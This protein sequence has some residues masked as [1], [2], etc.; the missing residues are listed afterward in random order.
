MNNHRIKFT[1]KE[2]GCDR[3]HYLTQEDVEV[4]LSR[5]PTELYARL[6]VVHFNDWQQRGRRTYGYVTTRGRRE[7]AICAL[8]P[9]VSLSRALGRRQSPAEYGARRQKQ[10]PRLPVRRF[11]LYEVFLHE[12]GHLQIINPKAKDPRRKFA[13]EKY[14]E[15]FATTWR[16]KLWS[17]PFDHP[18]RVHNPPSDW[19]RMLYE[20]KEFE[21]MLEKSAANSPRGNFSD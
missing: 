6:R 10:W 4:L 9:R 14:A 18:D 7:I 20:L 2:P 19:E 12:L 3:E 5:L 1:T 13:D 16:R 15:E 17:M 8:P 11:M 21:E